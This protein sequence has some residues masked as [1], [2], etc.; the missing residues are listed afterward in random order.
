MTF[1]GEERLK[2]LSVSGSERPDLDTLITL[3]EILSETNNQLT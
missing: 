3:N 1:H 2:T